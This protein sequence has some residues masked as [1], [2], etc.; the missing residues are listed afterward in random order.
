MELTFK[1]LKRREVINVADGKSLGYIV[2]LSISFPTGVFTGITVPGRKT[3]FLSGL[4]S[5]NE[6]FID[7][8]KIQKIG[9]DVI[10]VNLSCGDLCTPSVNA[11][12]KKPSPPS[13]HC[14]PFCP[15]KN[16]DGSNIDLG[17]Y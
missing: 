3:N 13:S 4:F 2:D 12:L 7:R 10:L 8:S 6:M 17:D 9:S 14:N 11:N 16:N 1:E 5:R 15:P